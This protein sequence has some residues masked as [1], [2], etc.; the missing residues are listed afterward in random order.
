MFGKRPSKGLKNITIDSEKSHIYLKD[1]N[2]S[3]IIMRPYD[4]VQL[5]DLVGT[6]SED[7]LIWTGKSI[8]KALINSI[9]QQ[10]K[11]IMLRENLLEEL[12][13]NLMHLGYGKF[14]MQYIEGDHVKIEVHNSI[15]QDIDEEEDAQ[16]I[17]NFYNGILIGFFNSTGIDVEL[18]K[19][20][21]SEDRDNPLYFE[22][23]FLEELEDGDEL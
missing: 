23:V 9:L 13:I 22:Y 6:G 19:L 1:T 8:G 2:F 4:L 18:K 11:K 5:G 7:I 21:C 12:L 17:C 15:L 16:L 14:L 3:L 20:I 10:K